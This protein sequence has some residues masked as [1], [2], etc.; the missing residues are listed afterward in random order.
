MTNP[1]QL[2]AT[3]PEYGPEV[4]KA[5]FCLSAYAG[6]SDF[7]SAG[8][9]FRHFRENPDDYEDRLARA[10]YTNYCRAVVRSYLNHLSRR[11]PYVA[12]DSAIARP[13]PRAAPVTIATR[14]VRSALIREL[15]CSAIR[16]IL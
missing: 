11:A 4:R 2:A 15:F 3:H 10:Y 7:V 8:N 1:D 13:R 9:L 14:S 5:E 12:G 6:G 16:L